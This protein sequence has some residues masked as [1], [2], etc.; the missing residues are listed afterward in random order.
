MPLASKSIVSWLLLPFALLAGGQEPAAAPPAA[1]ASGTL[2]VLN[3]A[4]AIASLIDLA[5]GKEVARVAT[6]VG[7]HAVIVS[8]D[9][10]IAVVAD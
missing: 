10:R 3:K 8:P 7:P 9:G 5:A 1:S 2:I 6:G 4:A